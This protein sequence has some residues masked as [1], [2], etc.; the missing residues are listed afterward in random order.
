MDYYQKT[1]I[2]NVMTSN[3]LYT[4]VRCNKF[5]IRNELCEEKSIQEATVGGEDG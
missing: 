5:D 4:F 3:A 2:D 1:Q